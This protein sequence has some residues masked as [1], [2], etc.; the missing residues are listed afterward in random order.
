MFSFSSLLSAEGVDPSQVKLVRH[1]DSRHLRTPFELW[2]A[3]DGSFET[4]Q[5][6]QGR[7][8]FEGAKYLASFVATPLNETIFVGVFS[9]RGIGQPPAGLVDP[10]SGTRTRAKVFY[11][12]TDSKILAEYRG[13]IVID[14]GSGYRSWVQRAGKQPKP[15]LEI[16]R[17]ETEPPF[18]GFLAFATPLNRLSSVPISWRTALGAVCG[19]YLLTCPRTGKHY[20]GSASGREGFWSRWQN[21]V[22][23]GHGGNVLMKKHAPVDFQV[24]ILEVVSSSTSSEELVRLESRWKQKLK[25][26]EF[27]LNAN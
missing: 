8:C 27:G 1:Q 7:R 22:A 13:R 23:S 16:R 10:I 17:H 9:I 12:L 2:R 5:R 14:W 19:I 3:K 26:R 11:D 6:I 18:P 25:S 21:Y 4:Y 15:V 24:T 20:V